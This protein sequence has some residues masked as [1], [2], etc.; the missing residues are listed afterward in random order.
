[1]ILFSD[2]R[3]SPIASDIKLETENDFTIDDDLA[4]RVDMRYQPKMALKAAIKDWL[5][6]LHSH[7][8]PPRQPFPRVIPTFLPG[9]SG[10]PGVPTDEPPG[11]PGPPVIQNPSPPL[12]DLPGLPTSLP[13]NPSIP[14]GVK[15]LAAGEDV[16][17]D[18]VPSAAQ[19]CMDPSELEAPSTP[20]ENY[21][22]PSPPAGLPLPD[23]IKTCLTP[24]FTTQT[25]TVSS[26]PSMSMICSSVRAPE[27]IATFL[28][29]PS[30]P[31]SS[32]SEAP[33]SDS[34]SDTGSVT[35]SG[36]EPMDIAMPSTSD[37]PDSSQPS[38]MPVG[39]DGVSSPQNLPV[40]EKQH[41][42]DSLMQVELDIPVDKKEDSDN[43]SDQVKPV[44]EPVFSEDDAL[45]LIDLF[46]MPFEHGSN[47]LFFLQ[48]LH[49]LRNNALSISKKTGH[50]ENSFE[51]SFVAFCRKAGQIVKI[52]IIT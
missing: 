3:M 2:E 30:L 22:P 4:S 24:A 48:R 18:E 11:P 13:G 20:P 41:S 38:P 28:Q 44:T 26:I 40:F 37:Y 27:P 8:E 52:Q 31:V 10:P 14:P 47:S 19:P 16:N 25:S 36:A 12:D 15:P 32:L 17:V 33:T 51:V 49:W 50:T 5:V 43:P 21:L 42:S 7:R 23:V 1:M 6:E 39:T 29:P 35:E 34:I 46:Y 45:G 9:S